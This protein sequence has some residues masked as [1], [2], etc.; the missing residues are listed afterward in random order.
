MLEKFT[1]KWSIFL[2]VSSCELWKSRYR[3]LWTRVLTIQY[4]AVIVREL[5]LTHLGIQCSNSITCYDG[6]FWPT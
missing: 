1:D 6:Y 2:P 4:P 5:L 3:Q